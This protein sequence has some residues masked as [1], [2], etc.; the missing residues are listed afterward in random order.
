VKVE[1][2]GLELHGYHGAL[3]EERERGQRFLVDIRF[4]PADARA[5]DS[6]DIADAVDYREVVTVVRAV[7]EGSA[8]HLLEALAAALAGALLTEL[9]IAWVEVS[10]RKP[11]VVLDRPVEHASVTV[12]RYATAS[13]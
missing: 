7:F 4:E 2:R 8:F 5:A 11:D 3:P 1:L 13:E 6:D 10:V 9:P 12:E